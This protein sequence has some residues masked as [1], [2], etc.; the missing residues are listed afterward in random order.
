MDRETEGLEPFEADS[1]GTGIEN[2]DINKSSNS[3]VKKTKGNVEKVAP[4]KRTSKDADIHELEY[5]P[6]E[7]V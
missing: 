6:N 7:K 4:R 5:S 1:D 2:T 3:F